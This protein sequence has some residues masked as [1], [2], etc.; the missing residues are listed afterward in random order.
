MKNKL[1]SA[2]STLQRWQ[3]K[4]VS[5]MET[6]LNSADSTTVCRFWIPDRTK[7]SEVT[8]R[9]KTQTSVRFQG[10]DY[11]SLEYYIFVSV[12][13][14]ISF[15]GLSEM[16][17][18]WE[19]SFCNTENSGWERDPPSPAIGRQQSAKQTWRRQTELRNSRFNVSTGEGGGKH[20]N[21]DPLC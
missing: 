19:A 8:D 11:P 1:A 3:R 12:H 15:F 2:Q 17:R 5:G 18:S 4:Q 6:R 21:S 16:R 14:N 13:V 20:W 7:G 10:L 9:P